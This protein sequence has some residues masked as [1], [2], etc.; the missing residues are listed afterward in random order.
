M[1][2][3]HW[4]D[5]AACLD[6]ELDLF[7][8]G[9]PNAIREA[10]AICKGCPVKAECLADAIEHGDIGIRGGLTEDQRDSRKVSKPDPTPSTRCG[11]YSGYGRHRKLGEALCVP[12]K[13]AAR[14]YEQE[15]RRKYGR[16]KA[17]A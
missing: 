7:F 6:V 4:R 2:D 1:A 16:R 10:K 5:R 14:A 11:T 12:C 17:S 8:H 3:I 13:Q 15:H 9:T